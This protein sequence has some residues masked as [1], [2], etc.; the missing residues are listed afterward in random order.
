MKIQLL[1]C[2]VLCV[3]ISFAQ[4][5]LLLPAGRGFSQLDNQRAPCGQSETGVAQRVAWYHDSVQQIEVNILG[6]DGGGVIQDR[7][8]CVLMGEDEN[9][10]EPLFPIKGAL[11]VQLPNVDFMVYQLFLRMPSNRCTGQA[12]LQLIYSTYGGKEFFQ[13][14]DLLILN[15][16]GQLGGMLFAVLFSVATLLFTVL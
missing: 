5:E 1:F 7:Y 13:C 15:G 10:T 3:S 6:A 4:L 12:T 2:L 9:P 11:Q 16:A 14:Q 8:S